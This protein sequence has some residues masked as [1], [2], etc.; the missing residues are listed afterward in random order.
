VGSGSREEQIKKIQH[1]FEP[2]LIKEMPDLVVV[3]G[4][5]NSTIACASVAKKHGVKVAHVE[6]GLR[7]SCRKNIT[8]E[9]PTGSPISC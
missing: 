1:L 4:D 7:S 3:V 2:V 9:R 8:E 5:V 6:A